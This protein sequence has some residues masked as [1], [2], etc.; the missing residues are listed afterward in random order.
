MRKETVRSLC[1]GLYLAGLWGAAY[2]AFP[3]IFGQTGAFGSLLSNHTF[4]KFLCIYIGMA[5]LTI[6]AMSIAFHRGHTHQAIKLNP[7]V[8]FGMQSFLWGV[9]SMSKL[10]WVSVHVFHHVHSDT[11]LD[12]HSPKQ[13][14][15]LHVFFLGALDYSEAK[16]WPEVLKIRNRIPA[17]RY[18]KFIS[19]HLFLGPIVLTALLMVLFGAKYGSILGILN[20]SISPIFAVG[21]VNA[22]AHA[23]GYQNYNSKDNSRNIGFLFFLNWIICGELDHNNHHKYPKSPSFA[24]RWFEFDVGWFYIRALKALGLA[25]VTG[26][27]PVYRSAAKEAKSLHTDIAFV[28]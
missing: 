13:K 21:G 3:L 4:L 15:L 20:F 25:Q 24:H 10:D 27:V 1:F 8:D 18:E 23:F 28:S 6:T 16:S 22:L 9:T 26:T 14:G 19:R 7:F 11:H 5:H 17:S 12:P 2:W